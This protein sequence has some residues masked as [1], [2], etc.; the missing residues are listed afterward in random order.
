MDTFETLPNGRWWPPNL[1][2]SW[3]RLLIC[4]VD[5]PVCLANH[6]YPT[7]ASSM[8]GSSFT[9]EIFG[10]NICRVL[11]NPSVGSR[12][13]FFIEPGVLILAAKNHLVGQRLV[14]TSH[15]LLI[16][17]EKYSFWFCCLNPHIGIVA[18]DLSWSIP[19]ISVLDFFFGTSL[20]SYID[21]ASYWCWETSFQ[22]SDRASCQ[23]LM[24]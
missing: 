12:H 4:P 19:N 1:H 6:P 21:L 10:S 16:N 5:K 11:W 17:A 7:G 13:R 24:S 18:G 15:D 20:P 2:I 22:P 14:T 8:M 3:D 23:F 9:G